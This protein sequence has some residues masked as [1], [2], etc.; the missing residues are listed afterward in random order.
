MPAR[1]AASQALIHQAL[2]AHLAEVG[3]TLLALALQLLLSESLQLR[4]LT[5]SGQHHFARFLEL[6][7]QLCILLAQVLCLLHLECQPLLT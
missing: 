1:P 5:T 7:L 6:L 4:L 2:H 3:D